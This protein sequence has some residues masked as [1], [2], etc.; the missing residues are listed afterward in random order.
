[1]KL[2]RMVRSTPEHAD[3]P[4]ECDAAEEAVQS[5]K[6]RGWKEKDGGSEK[7]PAVSEEKKPSYEP[8]QKSFKKDKPVAESEEKAEEQDKDK[9]LF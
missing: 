3:G 5:Y 2:V 7:K 4:V 9:D 1:M 8:K 6:A